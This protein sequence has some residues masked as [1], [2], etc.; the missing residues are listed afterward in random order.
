M[1]FLFQPPFSKV[2]NASYFYFHATSPDSIS[3]YRSQKQNKNAVT[4][5]HMFRNKTN[6]P[7][8]CFFILFKAKTINYGK[9]INQHKDDDIYHFIEM[10]A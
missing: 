9:G 7:I 5:E 1:H 2:R 10:V 6:H 4:L 3:N 8:L